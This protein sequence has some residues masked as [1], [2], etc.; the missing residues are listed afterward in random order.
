MAKKR[1]SIATPRRP[2]ASADAF[3]AGKK[4]NGKP[5]KRRYTIWLP[6]QVATSFEHWC[7]SNRKAYSDR[8]TELIRESLR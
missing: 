1:V 4:K 3:V 8:V 7:V 2:P 5:T 6:E